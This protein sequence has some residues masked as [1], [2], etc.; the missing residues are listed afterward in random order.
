MPIEDTIGL[1]RF[2]I[3]SRFNAS[4]RDPPR[5]YRGE[6]RALKRLKKQ[7]ISSS[8]GNKKVF[9]KIKRWGL[10]NVYSR[11]LAGGGGVLSRAAAER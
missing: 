11:V 4:Q 2:K 8:R 9:G 3:Q 10:K 5:E 7:L 6:I 1:L